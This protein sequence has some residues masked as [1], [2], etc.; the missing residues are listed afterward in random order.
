MYPVSRTDTSAKLVCANPHTYEVL[1]AKFQ[2]AAV[3]DAGGTPAQILGAELIF[4]T[5]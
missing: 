2:Q 5:L 4:F 1:P 3:S